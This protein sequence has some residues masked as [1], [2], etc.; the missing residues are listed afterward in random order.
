MHM[1]RSPVS[2]RTQFASKN[3]KTCVEPLDRGRNIAGDYPIAPF[4]QFRLQLRA[5]QIDGAP[6]ARLARFGCGVLSVNHARA[7]REAR[8]Q[9]S[10]RISYRKRSGEYRTR[11]DQPCAGDAEA[12][13]HGEAEITRRRFRTAIAGYFE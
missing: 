5:R 9:H 1:N 7:E 4:D 3:A 2:Q 10:Q 13:I 11:D 12:A 8:V 6:L